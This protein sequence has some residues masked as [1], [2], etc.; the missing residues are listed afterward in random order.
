VTQRQTNAVGTTAK[1]PA[2]CVGRNNVRHDLP[3][4]AAVNGIELMGREK[5]PAKPLPISL[6]PSEKKAAKRSS[7]APYVA[8]GT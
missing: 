6:G 2:R 7:T 8:P 3:L 4:T 1:L 5:V